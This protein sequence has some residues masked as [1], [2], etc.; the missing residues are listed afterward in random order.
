MKH[1]LS[2]R[3]Q[4]SKQIQSSSPSVIHSIQSEPLLIRSKPPIPIQKHIPDIQSLFQSVTIPTALSP[5]TPKIAVP[6]KFPK[7]AT[8]LTEMAS[9]PRNMLQ[10]LQARKINSDKPSSKLIEN[11][12]ETQAEGKQRWDLLISLV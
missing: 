12:V 9:T 6:I 8:L 5:A 10:A 7:T 2:Q 11:N 1:H 4:E 3:M